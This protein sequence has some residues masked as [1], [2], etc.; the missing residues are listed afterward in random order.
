MEHIINRENILKSY[1]GMST[2]ECS[3]KLMFFLDNK[4]ECQKF[5]KLN[6]PIPS[7]HNMVCNLGIT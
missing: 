5:R 2:D 7:V 6:D 1:Q 4:T 3:T